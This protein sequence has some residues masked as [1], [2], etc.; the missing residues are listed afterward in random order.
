MRREPVDSEAI[1]SIGYDL[2]RQVLEVEF[3]GGAVY[4]YF[5][6]PDGV[7]VELMQAASLGEAFAHRV[8]NAGFEYRQ[9]RPPRS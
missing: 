5:D 1:R 9:V 7:Y 2:G 8:R 6:V 4:R 3:H